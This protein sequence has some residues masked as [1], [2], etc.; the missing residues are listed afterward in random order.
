MHEASDAPGPQLLMFL[1]AFAGAYFLYVARKLRRRAVDLY[2]F[3]LLLALGIVPLL[4]A[5]W[6]PVQDFVRR[7]FGVAL[8]LTVMFGLMFVAVF[9]ILHRLISRVNALE[10][11]LTRAVQEIGLLDQQL[12]A[13][14]RASDGGAVRQDTT[15]RDSVTRP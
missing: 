11:K 2:D 5:A 7:F 6:P 1:A 4:F 9:L 8:P 14:K 3:P 13:A 10:S 15:E 12:R